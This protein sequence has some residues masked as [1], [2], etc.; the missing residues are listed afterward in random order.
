M[1]FYGF[2]QRRVKRQ[3]LVG[4]LEFYETSRFPW[5]SEL[6]SNWA[7]IRKEL[8]S[9]LPRLDEF[10]DY[11]TISPSVIKLAKANKWRLFVLYLFGKKFKRN[12]D[13]CPV[14]SK[15]LK[16]I[17]G[18]KTG[19]FSI[20]TPGTHLVPH[21]GPYAGVLRC[22]LALLVPAEREKCW[23]RVGSTVRNWEE[24]KAMIFDETNVHEAMNDSQENRVV[25]FID[26]KRPLPF[27][28]GIMNEMMLRLIARTSHIKGAERGEK[29]WEK[30]FY[31]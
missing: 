29:D 11:K 28:T 27:F 13:L 6:E 3:S 19:H 20:L 5:V 21:T 26:F 23:L 25:L 24:G 10:P 14:T 31:K 22:H 9:I 17:P 18:M 7:A 30:G 15:V 8:D 1:T 12:C 16:A 2:M 4:A